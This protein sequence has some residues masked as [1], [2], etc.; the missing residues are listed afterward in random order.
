M[1]PIKRLNDYIRS[2]RGV[3]FSLGQHDCLTF[4]NEAF[5][6]FHGF[7]YADDWLGRYMIETPYGTRSMRKDQ[8]RT[9]FGCFTFEDAVDQRLDR[10]SH[11]PPRGALVATSRVER[12]MIGN[13]LGICVGTKAAFLSRA[14]VVYSP[15][16][17]IDRAWMPK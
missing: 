4:S 9:E 6:A 8:L 15:L 14:G 1:G 10:V 3:P 7:G 16:D 2:V 13:A 5:R 17:D 12:W 11:I